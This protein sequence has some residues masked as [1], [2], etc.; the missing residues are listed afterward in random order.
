MELSEKLLTICKENNIKES[1]IGCD[2]WQVLCHLSPMRENLLEWFEFKEDA[3]LLEIG[4]KA[5][6][7]TGLF[8]KRVGKVICLE[9]NQDLMTVNIQ[10]NSECENVEFRV[11]NLK[12]IQQN[13]KYDYIT[14]IG[15]LEQAHQYDETDNPYVSLL[16]TCKE[17]LKD[18]GTII[19]A[20]DN[21]TAMKYWA[22]AP[23]NG[24]RRPFSGI[25]NDY[26]ENENR[27]FTKMEL[28][29]M[30]QQCDLKQAEFYYPVP[31]YRFMSVLYSEEFLPQQGELRP[32][33]TVYEQGGYQFF[34][35]DL[36]YDIVCQDGLYSYFADSFL[37]FVKK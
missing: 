21:K 1:L 10:R 33:N 29:R 11:G 30:I 6:A 27:S 23:E 25:N 32:G 8:A 22:G 35:E 15:T 31:D 13:E 28:E 4:S 36:A 9:N 18:D 5:G 26:K 17:H 3:V 19:I 34:E 14:L 20:L 2:D 37:I 16:N 12:Q 7:M 24:T